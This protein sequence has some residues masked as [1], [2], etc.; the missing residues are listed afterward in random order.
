MHKGLHHVR[1]VREGARPWEIGCPYC[2]FIELQKNKENSKGKGKGGKTSRKTGAKSKSKSKKAATGKGKKGGLT[3]VAGIGD[4]IATQLQSAGIKTQADL[5]AADAD[6]LS[7]KLAKVSKKR[8][9][10]W[11]STVQPQTSA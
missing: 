9:M 7:G 1:I 6:E 11:Q 2:S 5:A 10:G 3:D 4:A 8:I